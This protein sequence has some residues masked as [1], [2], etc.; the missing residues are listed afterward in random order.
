MELLPPSVASADQLRLLGDILAVGP[1]GPSQTELRLR[2]MTP[3]FSWQ[4]L[5]DQA[6][7]Q[8][9]MYP[10]VWAL[11]RRSLLL[12]MPRR[13]PQPVSAKHPTAVMLAVYDEYLQRQRRRRDQLGAIVSAFN[14]VNVEPLLLKGSR[15]L[16][17]NTSPWCEARDMRDLD[18]LVRPDDAAK[19]AKALEQIGYRSGEVSFPSDHHLPV[20]WLETAPSAVEVHSEALSFEAR[21]I[22]PT[23]TVWQQA[24][25]HT[26]EYGAFLALPDEWQFLVGLLHHQV[27]D[28]GYPR[29]VLALKTLWEIAS[30]GQEMPAHA[31]QSVAEYMALRRQ[32]D[33]LG[34]FVAQA[35]RLFALQPPPGID[36][37]PE[38]RAH[39]ESTYR[40]AFW[41]YPVRRGLFLADQLRF[42]FAGTTLA[43]RY[44]TEPS[45]I[46]RIRRHLNF[47]TRSH[48]G[49]M[50][51]RLTGR[52]DTIA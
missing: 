44:G 33:V 32:G 24:T 23:E 21:E 42:S 41:P 7:S 37:S 50:L 27:S 15:Y 48:R 28:R 43:M 8:G 11:K 51:L 3:G 9:L 1:T 40:R 39:A 5:A 46:G 6:G 25:R 16:L 49:R 45:R 38:A 26:N 2:V 31:W 20:M 19:A 22:L 10:L 18:L 47:L 4:Q 34:S 29:R 30:I 52:D 17:L 12:P 35:S 13:A 36:I 14:S